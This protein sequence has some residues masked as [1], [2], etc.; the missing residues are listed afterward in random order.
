MKVMSTRLPGVLLIEPDVFADARGFFLETFQLERYEA[1]LGR[2]LEFTQDNQSRSVGRVLRGL[3]FQ[4]QFPQEKLVRV[5]RGAVYDVA[6]NVNPDSPFFGQWLGVELSEANH[7]QLFIPAGYAHGFQVLGDIADFEY[8]CI[9]AYR[10]DDESG[11]LWSDPEVGIC[12]PI[13][14]PLLS[15]KDRRLPSL[16]QLR[17]GAV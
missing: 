9:G 12:W 14:E 11:L 2:R 7:R 5:V 15:D 13:S 3:H 6:V 16:A 10:P 1:A 17:Q 8:K 4:R